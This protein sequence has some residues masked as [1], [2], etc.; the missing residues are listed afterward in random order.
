MKKTIQIHIGGRHFHMDEDAYLKLN[1][2]LESLKLH[3][4]ADKDSGKEIVED[5]EQRVAELLENRIIP[6]KQ[7]IT[8]EDVEETIK[9]LGKVE[10]FIYQGQQ[11][12]WKD[13]SWDRRDNRRLYRDADNYYIG[14]VASG[15]GA[16]FDIDP[17]WIRIALVALIFLKGLGVIIYAILWIAL[18]K[19]R[20]T[21]EK[22]QMK[23]MPVNLSTIKESVSAEYDR[24]KTNLGNA[25]H[26]PAAA[27]TRD[28]FDN[29]L[30]AVGLV[31]VAIFK[32]LIGAIGVLF[33]VLGAILLAVMVLLLLGFTNIFG[34]WNIWNDAQV[35]DFSQL[36]VNSG[37]YYLVIIAFI[38]VV[39][40]PVVALIYGG[41]KILFNIN[42]K[43]PVLRAF[44]LTSWILALILFVT[45]IILHSSSLAVESSTSET[46]DLKTEHPRVLVEVNDNT[47]GKKIT[48]NSVLG[49]RFNYSD[50]DNSLYTRANLYIDESTDASMHLT[51]N[52]KV[53][54]IILNESD[55]YIHRID[56]TWQQQ[57]SVIILD[58]YLRSDDEDF[59]MLGEVDIKLEI[60]ENQ[61]VVLSRQSC[62][63]LNDYQQS[64]YCSGDSSLIG[65]PGIMTADGLKLLEK[66]KSL[67]NRK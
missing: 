20:S 66:Q 22:L 52:K 40:V 46:A 15:L 31:F 18:P 12:E 23:G 41:I 28:A 34:H 8:M 59:W 4:A 64:R 14:G 27:H 51:V 47:E 57:D 58:R 45:L 5:I 30:R 11:S 19:A 44:V 49:L 50:R 3:F 13:S 61:V 36:F 43:H 29:L 63:L 54:N 7:A 35:P 1:H 39:A 25:A 9:V 6:G 2:Y 17:V 67:P 60:P 53:K 10:D 56:Y 62:D 16:Y 65:R 24:V 42:T 48:V 38:I 21:A 55:E 26:S 32:F 37:H 33:M